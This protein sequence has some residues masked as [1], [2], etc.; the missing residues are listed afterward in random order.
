M[1]PLVVSDFGVRMSVSHA[2]LC[3]E[4]K[5]RGEIAR[6]EP[7]QS[8]YD[9]VVFLTHSGTI[10]LDAL[11][12]LARHKIPVSV[13]DW[14]GRLQTSMTHSQVNHGALRLRQYQAHLD[15]AKRREIGL[16]LIREKARQSENVL[17]ELSRFYPSVRALRLPIKT[18]DDEGNAALAYFGEVAKVFKSLGYPFN[19]RR[20]EADS[21]NVKAASIVNALLN[22][23]YSLLEAI[24]RREVNAAG[25]DASIGFVHSTFHTSEP[26]V[27]DIQ[28]LFR[29]LID[30]S[31]VQLLES[32]PKI[33]ESDFHRN[34]DFSLKLE[35]ETAKRLVDIIK[36]NFNTITPYRG[37]PQT[38]E[39]VL[40][41]QV[42]EL[43]FFLLVK[44][45]RLE[46]DS[47]SFR[48]RRNDDAELRQLIAGLTPEKRKALGL[49]KSTVH[50]LKKAVERGEKRR[51]Y[52]KVLAKLSKS[53]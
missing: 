27:F 46:F 25:L 35:P 22:Y 47:P 18:L 44:R 49:N 37:R 15:A 19:G 5:A 38:F 23:G 21:S 3:L 29:W 39:S 28:E 48:V 52:G 6:I 16:A 12:W 26:L 34:E 8:Q 32:K 42:R 13:L 1:N 20:N 53:P 11:R 51:V 9:S 36:G 30:L 43:A 14:R 41:A 2:S 33:T 7:R 4:S 17:G 10:S 24:I 45:A 40:V 50:Y 31:V